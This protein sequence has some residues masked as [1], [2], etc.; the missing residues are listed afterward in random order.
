MTHAINHVAVAVPDLE[1]AVKW[2]SDVF[3]MAQLKPIASHDRTTN[4]HSGIFRIYPPSLNKV[5]N[6]CLSAGN[7]VGLELFQFV[8]PAIRPG[9]EANLERDIERGGYFHMAV[10]TADVDGL[11]EEVVRRGGRLIGEKVPVYQYEACYVE[12]PWGNVV[13]LLSASFERVMSNR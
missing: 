9:S 10:T 1:A 7:G 4:P 11:V 12:D 5:R 2:Y 13:E 3:G 6:A 8:D